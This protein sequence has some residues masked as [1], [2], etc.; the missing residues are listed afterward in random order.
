MGQPDGG[1]PAVPPAG[2]EPKA[3]GAEPK[4]LPWAWIFLVLW[5]IWLSALILMSKDEWGRAKP[6]HVP[7]EPPPS[8]IRKQE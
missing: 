7:D 2:A 8:K 5:L 1:V 3:A 4:R 6:T